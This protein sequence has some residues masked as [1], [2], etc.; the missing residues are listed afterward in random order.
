MTIFQAALFA[1]EQLF[2]KEY[3]PVPIFVS[4]HENKVVEIF[5]DYF[6][7]RHVHLPLTHTIIDIKCFILMKVRG[8]VER[9][10]LSLTVVS[11]IFWFTIFINHFL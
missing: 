10:N 5:N 7:D 8:V 2:E 1:I 6:T 4:N 3:K 9:I 11:G